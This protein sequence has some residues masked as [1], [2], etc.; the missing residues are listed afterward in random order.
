MNMPTISSQRTSSPLV[1]T[2]H[3]TWH[4]IPE[5]SLMW[6]E[7]HIFYWYRYNYFT[8]PSRK[9]CQ[10]VCQSLHNIGTHPKS[11]TASHQSLMHT[12]GNDYQR[13]R[14]H[15]KESIALT[16]PTPSYPAA[17]LPVCTYL[18]TGFKELSKLWRTNICI[19]ERHRFSLDI[20]QDF[21]RLQRKCVNWGCSWIHRRQT[22]PLLPI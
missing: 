15:K 4:Y 21:R 13:S 5:Y 2:Y 20:S 8:P 12:D 17:L 3:T 7:P 6:Q 22:T 1:P 14:V 16:D 19:C 10:S 18:L 11:L 9:F